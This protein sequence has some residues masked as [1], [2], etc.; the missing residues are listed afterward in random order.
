MKNLIK[1][2]L[3][4]LATQPLSA[5]TGPGGVGNATDNSLWL[6]AN[7]GT[8]STIDNQPIDLWMDQSGNG[9][10]VRQTN[11][12]Q[13]PLYRAA[14]MNG[15]PAIQFDNANTAGQNDF[16]IA[17]NHPSLDGTNG[18]T[19]MT[20]TRR[21]NTGSARAI[22][23][24]RNNLNN[25]NAYMFF[26]FES[27]RVYADIDNNNNRFFLPGGIGAGSN[28][29]LSLWY[30]G[31][32]DPAL[33]ARIYDAENAGAPS[34]EASAAIPAYNSPL[35]LGT[36][37]LG[38][39]RAFGGLMSEIII[40]RKALNNSE[41][42]IVNNYLSAKYEIP[43]SINKLYTMDAPGNGN[44]DHEVA[45]IGRISANDFH[46]DAKGTGLVRISNPSNLEDGEFLFWGHNNA[47]PEAVD[48][49][50]VPVGVEARFERVWRVS[51]VNLAGAAVDV[52]A[53]DMRF[54]LNG[55]GNVNPAEVVLLVDTDS[56]GIFS[57]ETPI[58][59][60]THVG[61][62]IYQF[63]G[64]TAIADTRRFTLG[65]T[66]ARFTPLPIQL[67]S[68][69]GEC[70][71]GKPVLRWTTATE[72][73]NAYFTIERSKDGKSWEQMAQV[74]GAGNSETSINYSFSELPAVKGAHFYRLKQT[75]YDGTFTHSAVISL[76]CGANIAQKMT[77]Y[78]NPAS[79]SVVI[80][81][82][83]ELAEIQIHDSFGQQ[84]GKSFTVQGSHNLSIE[85]LTPGIYLI[86]GRTD[87]GYFTQRLIVNR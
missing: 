18:L 46:T 25:Q 71:N 35:L 44:F 73:D 21:T 65:T 62:N 20:V 36:T 17:N 40:Y 45:G 70:T 9:N 33:R 12:P 85:D 53:V 14:Q 8:S 34:T 82:M 77:V 28:R 59:G 84:I 2:A 11:A 3:L 24:K 56:D 7:A 6:R 31:T 48:F 61:G 41:R 5:Q 51:E 58:F 1:L 74:K 49:T 43:M 76:D 68:W 75:D 27:N 52:G 23:S 30:D 22:V 79:K 81:F 42:I 57:N 72:K 83:G 15:F 37:H 47:F 66:N 69:K 39:T 16:M 86:I 4:L 32:L 10:H 63:T 50:D 19:I 13:Q 87:T 64:V 60:A 38:D 67:T 80:D 54:D 26:F 29:I 55:L 78:P